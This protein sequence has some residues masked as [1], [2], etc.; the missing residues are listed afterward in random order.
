MTQGLTPPVFAVKLTSC[1]SPKKGNARVLCSKGT[2]GG[3]MVYIE[4][5]RTVEAPGMA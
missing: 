1:L 3:V 4:S 2:P 5:K